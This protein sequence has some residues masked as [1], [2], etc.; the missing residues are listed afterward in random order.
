MTDET[1]RLGDDD[2]LRINPSFVPVVVTEDEVHFRAGTWNKN[3]YRIR[4]DSETG[5][6]ESLVDSLRKGARIETVLSAFDP[7][8]RDDVRAVVGKLHDSNV[9]IESDDSDDSPPDR[10]TGYLSLKEKHTEDGDLSSSSVTVVGSGTLTEMLTADLVELGVES[11]TVLDPSG[12]ADVGSEEVVEYRET[13]VED[14]TEA[15]TSADLVIATTMKPR[16]DRLQS[17]NRLALDAQTPCLFARIHGF[18]GMVGPTVVPGET[19]CF[20]CLGQRIETSVPNEDTLSA[21]FDQSS[22]TDSAVLTP[23]ARVLAGH[24][25]S[26]AMHQLTNR[27]GFTVGRMLSVDFYDFEID[28]DDVLKLPRCSACGVDSP[29]EQRFATI[30]QVI[31][32]K[33]LADDDEV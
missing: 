28:S 16:R 26:E 14:A 12:T 25:A 19:A 7:E 20:E 8:K 1:P 24:A 10:Y 31:E 18:D 23:F 21:Y 29:P 33:G 5:I 22:D 30:D 15:F 6:L 3:G 27:V 13:G 17:V 32:S 2:Y 4:D 11:V 9:L